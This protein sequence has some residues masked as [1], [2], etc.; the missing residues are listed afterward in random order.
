MSRRVFVL[1]ATLAAVCTFSV[2]AASAAPAGQTAN[3]TGTPAPLRASAPG[4]TAR[5]VII[6]TTLPLSGPASLYARI[7]TGMRSYLSYINARRARDGSRGVYGRQIILN[8][9]D[10]QYNEAL[11]V[12]QTRRA[13][14]ADRVFAM[15][16]GLGTE[17]QQAVR[18][19]MNQRKVPQ[20]YVSTGL[21]EF[22]SL[23]R[24][25]PWTIGWQPDYVQE[26]ILLG[27][28]VRQN[29]PNAKVAVLRQND[30]YG[31]EFLQGFLAGAGG[32]FVVATETYP[33][34]GGAAVI[35]GPV[36]RLRASGADT[37]LVIATPTEAVTAL[38]TAFRIG[39]RPNKLVNS[40][41][42]TTT[43]MGLA[44]QSAGSPEAVNGVVTTTYLKDCN[45]PAYENDARVRMYKA[46]MARYAP[47]QPATDCLFFYGMA[48]ADTFVQALYRAGRNPT[49]ASMMNAVRNLQ[50]PSP[51]LI[52][53]ARVITTPRSAFPIR[54]QKLAR[55]NN[56]N[57]TE[58]GTLQRT[59]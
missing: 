46:I 44:Q 50:M 18:G 7:G 59:R 25:Y 42:A 5:N 37:F 54:H 35:P 58:F 1:V 21:S 16:G 19:Y 17:N 23:H 55:Y 53:G 26:G 12:Q 36:S 47:G 52:P 4:V 3:P 31:R 40:V 33:R 11:T 24:Q 13:V 8:V 43:F 49:R 22:G 10:D 29:L 15:L 41:A 45:S 56:G 27:R 39:W 48:K 30:D 57:F 9:Y 32:G 38:V 20:L 51:W 14:E 2:T 6:G 28:Y 34:N